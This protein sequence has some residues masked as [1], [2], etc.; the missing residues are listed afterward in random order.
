MYYIGIIPIRYEQLGNTILLFF[1]F[2]KK[3]REI[4][5][6][7]QLQLGSVCLHH[8]QVIPLFRKKGICQK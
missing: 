5:F 7:Q 8:L 2:K 6:L 4:N 3:E 1:L